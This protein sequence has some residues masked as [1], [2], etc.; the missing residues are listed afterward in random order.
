MPGDGGLTV[1][2]KALDQMFV[3]EDTQG[4]VFPVLQLEGRLDVADIQVLAAL[5]G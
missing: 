5:A 3:A 2:G 4:E 1:V